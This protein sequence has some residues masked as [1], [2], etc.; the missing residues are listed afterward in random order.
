[1]G[2]SVTWPSE[3]ICL[4]PTHPVAAEL[5]P[6]IYKRT[7]RTTFDAPGFCAINLGPNIGSTALRQLMVDIKHE[8]ARLHAS[9]TGQTL[10]YLSAA[11]FDQQETTR[12]HLDG[13]PDECFLMLG[14]EPSNVDSRLE[15]SDYSRC[16]FEL[17]ITPKQFMSQHNQMFQAGYEMLQ[18]YTTRVPGFSQSDYQIICVNNSSADY[19][20][21]S[22]SWQGTLHTAAIATPDESERRVINS[23]MIASVA[24]GTPD[25]VSAAQQAE[26]I[27]TSTVR[28]RGY[29]KPHLNDDT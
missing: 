15:I 9:T 8:M 19:S 4:Q 3:S 2:E 7:C 17:G 25:S 28:W 16:A 23:T 12:P 22:Q 1:M 14:Y 27:S 29:D 18:P 10:A 6:A 13:G 5:A 21:N 26:F 20:P 24:V 11:R